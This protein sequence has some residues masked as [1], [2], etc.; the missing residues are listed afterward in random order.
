MTSVPLPHFKDI[1]VS[2][3]KFHNC[4]MDMDLN[5]AISKEHRRLQI[6]VS[7]WCAKAMPYMQHLRKKEKY[8]VDRLH[9]LL[10]NDLYSVLPQ[11][12]RGSQAGHP[13]MG[14]SP[15]G[16]PR[17]GLGTL[18]ISAVTGLITLAVESLGSYLRNK[19]EKRIND[20]VLAMRE[21]NTAVQNTLQ[22]YSNDFLMYGCYNVETLE[23]V[24]QTVNSLHHRQ[25]QLEEV[26]AKTQSGRV[27]EVIDA[28]SFNFD[29]QLYMKL[30]EEEHV[31]QYQLLEKASHD[32]LKGIETLGQ[33]KLPRELVSDTR[34]RTMLK[35]VRSMI[36]KQF[37]DYELAD[38]SILHYRDMKLVTFS[39]DRE[40]HS[41][42][43]SFPVFV[44]DFRQPPLKLYEVDTVAVPIPD[45]NNKA[46]SYTKVSINKPYLAAG[47]DYYIQLKMTELVMCKSIRHTYYCEELFVVKHKSRHSCASAIF[48]DLGPEE[49][50]L[51]CQ[52]DYIYNTTM[53][54]TILDGGRSLLLANF[55]GPRSLKCNSKNGGLP[56]PAPEHVYAVVDRSFLCDCQLDLE[57][58]A[59][60]LR[61][62][63]SCTD[64]RTAHFRVE[65]VV[66][67]GFYQ[68]LRNRHPKLVENVRPNARGWT[69]IFNVRLA[70]ADQT[71]L[72]EPTD[73][74][75]ALECIGQHGR[76]RPIV[77]NPHT[78][79]PPILA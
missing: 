29:L 68:L 71:P 37:P 18:V 64:N 67:L 65:F 44:K 78:R 49:V 48:Y 23:K 69:Q 8:F 76:L 6:T 21:D 32:L 74:K 31:N 46:N 5:S 53:P 70:P 16:H 20:A 52:F 59:T 56:K 58:H 12:R 47:D 28:I 41:L 35:E 73:L 34:L 77:E 61:Q 42:I 50:V 3:L 7:E 75:D 39:I 60:I 11:L 19:Q 1:H 43:I 66:N 14:F 72:G 10:E 57:H 9:G 15:K 36:R 63:S 30:V 4:S 25:T 27:D 22:Q 79:P 2:P 17:R 45:R 38:T 55:H 40:T 26:F 24:I 13:Q 51:K 62:L 33:G 54:P